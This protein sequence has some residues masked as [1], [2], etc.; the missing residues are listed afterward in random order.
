MKV[1]TIVLCTIKAK[2]NIDVL[3]SVPQTTF[4]RRDHWTSCQLQCCHQYAKCT[5]CLLKIEAASA[6]LA[7][8][9]ASQL[10]WTDLSDR[11][12]KLN[13]RP[14][15]L[16]QLTGMTALLIPLATT[17]SI[18]RGT[19]FRPPEHTRSKAQK[20]CLY[21]WRWPNP[22]KEQNNSQE[23]YIFFHCQKARFRVH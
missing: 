9:A 22:T 11:C 18:S 2:K 19:W 23:I 1:F 5:V 4:P 16:P 8:Q 7:Q 12:Q 15:L 13:I 6:A 21:N 3:V 17:M 14:K 20:S 10:F